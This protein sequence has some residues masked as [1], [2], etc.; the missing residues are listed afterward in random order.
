MAGHLEAVL[1]AEGVRTFI[2]NRHL[3]G[4][5][6]DLPPIEAWPEIW[7]HDDRDVER[8]RRII[9]A[10]LKAPAR[11]ES[12]QCPTCGETLEPQFDACWQCAGTPSGELPA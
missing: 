10:L 1:E 4:A 6:G 7:V 12:W 9:E 5:A 2:K 3:I 8:A 11:T